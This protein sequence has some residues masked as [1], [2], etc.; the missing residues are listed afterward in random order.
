MGL[1]ILSF[2]FTQ[3]KVTGVSGT[4]HPAAGTY[5]FY[6]TVSTD[7]CCL[8]DERTGWHLWRTRRKVI[9]AFP[10]FLRIQ[11]LFFLEI[12]YF[13]N[14]NGAYHCLH[15]G[16]LIVYIGGLYTV[17]L[18]IFNHLLQEQKLKIWKMKENISAVVKRHCLLCGRAEFDW[19]NRTFRIGHI[20]H[21]DAKGSPPPRCFFEIVLPRL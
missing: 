21:S 4:A 18:K 17:Y 2:D 10:T 14:E 8:L 5:R 16:P 11:R 1:E 9:G 12:A 3:P 13:G 19:S 7:V 20:G 6:K 15:S